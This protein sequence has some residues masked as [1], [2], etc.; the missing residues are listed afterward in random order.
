VDA[1]AR[2]RSTELLAALAAGD[3]TAFDPLYSMLSPRVRAFCRR[4]MGNDADGDD[5]AQDALLKVFERASEF[6]PERDAMT[7]ALGVAAWE[8]RSH[9]RR[10]VRRRESPPGEDQAAGGETPEAVLA[11]RELEAAA[12]LVLGEL[13]AVD[14]QTIVAAVTGEASLRGGV[15]PAA[16]RKRL[17]RAMGRLR[18]A[19]RSRYGAL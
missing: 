12:V 11:A 17:E 4:A 13:S 10:V 19:W 3:R 2:R 1:A 7:F 8:C 18:V 14:V 5:V 16:F 6:D 9:R 15:E